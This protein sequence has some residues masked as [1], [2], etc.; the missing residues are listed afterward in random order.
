MR[1]P[2]RRLL[3]GYILANS[4]AIYFHLYASLVVI[5]QFLLFLGVA[6]RQ[7]S[8]GSRRKSMGWQ[9]ARPLL[10]AFPIIVG[11]AV[12]CYSPVLVPL[13]ENVHSSVK[14][15]FNI[16]FPLAVFT[17]LSGGAPRL[18]AIMIVGLL[19]FGVRSLGRFDS[20]AAA[21]IGLLFLLPLVTLWLLRPVFLY[22]RFFIFL[23]PYFLL[24]LNVGLYE[25][26]RVSYTPRFMLRG[27]SYIAIAV[28]V[29]SLL[30]V[31]VPGC[32]Y[33]SSDGFREAAEV[34]EAGS[35]RNVLFCGLGVDCT[36]FQYYS[37]QC[38]YIPLSV[39]EWEN[40]VRRFPEVRCAY[41]PVVGFQPA[42][43]TAIAQFLEANSEM[44][45]I[46]NIVVFVWRKSPT[47]P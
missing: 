47:V 34:L 41:Y 26:W 22:P 19:L 31:W 30:V 39:T 23:L 9:E 5:V 16:S 43:H 4:A 10:F 45:K 33:I 17:M 29:A 13:V 25:L 27:G 6:L 20:L 15:D 28:I 2:S 12:L 14:G 21:Y 1:K 35:A 38:L 32:W 37:R 11:V 18:I 8:V 40:K 42:S 3:L 24:L 44:H 46:E 7:T 36:N